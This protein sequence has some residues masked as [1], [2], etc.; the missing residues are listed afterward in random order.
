MWFMLGA[1]CLVLVQPP[2]CSAELLHNC[3]KVI[4]STERLDTADHLYHKAGKV[5]SSDS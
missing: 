2:D 5:A 3:W 4:I 1:E